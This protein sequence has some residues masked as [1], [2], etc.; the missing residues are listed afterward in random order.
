MDGNTG[1]LSSG[2]GRG[3]WNRRGAMSVMR[4]TLRLL[5]GFLSAIWLAPVFAG[6]L[7]YVCLDLLK[8]KSNQSTF[9]PVR[10]L[11]IPI[12]DGSDI[13]AVM[14]DG[15]RIPV[16]PLAAASQARA[17]LD[18]VAGAMVYEKTKP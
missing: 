12:R 10:T 8:R 7:L 4:W 17:W 11:P 15:S 13:F 1:N 3:S 5:R 2:N 16:T 6:F 9:P 18:V 14:P